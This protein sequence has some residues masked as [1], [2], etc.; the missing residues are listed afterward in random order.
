MSKYRI[1]KLTNLSPL[2]IGTGRENYDFSSASLSSDAI[3]AALASVRASLGHDSDI[4]SFL[5]SF[6]ISSAFP[7]VGNQYFLPNL[8]RKINVDKHQEETYR[9][10][11]KKIKFVESSLWQTIISGEPIT[12]DES[13]LQKEFLIKSNTDFSAPSKT[14]VMQ[15]VKV[16]HGEH[17]SDPFFFEWTYFSPNAGLFCIVDADDQLF[18]E[19]LQLFQL[20][21]VEGIG[22]DKNIGGG[23][24]DV[25][26]GEISLCE[27]SDANATMLLSTYIPSKD[28]VS[29]LNLEASA[30]ELILR[31]GYMAGSTIESLRHL[32]KKSIYI[33]NVGSVFATTQQLQGK[34]VDLT[35]QWNDNRLHPIYRSGRPFSIKI[36]I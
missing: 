8:L 33:F 10:R 24:F 6:A 13:Q 32:R 7:F 27:P 23:K 1:I 5:S 35:P 19:L 28:E 2:H 15:R 16:A 3:S 31:N 17:N 14:N 21:G 30:Y 9:K 20:L 22:T 11:L 18:S 29:V 34:I 12:I 4:N 25:E 36:K 26:V